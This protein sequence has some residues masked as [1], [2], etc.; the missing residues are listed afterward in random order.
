MPD[1]STVSIAKE[2][3]RVAGI[4][5]SFREEWRQAHAATDKR[6]DAHQADIQDLKGRP[7]LT[8]EQAQWVADRHRE[9]EQAEEH[10]KERKRLFTDKVLNV[11]MYPVMLAIGTGTTLVLGHLTHLIH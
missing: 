10:R 8:L 6:L 1:E 4:V 7:V 5:E 11:A 2:L 9:D 3:G